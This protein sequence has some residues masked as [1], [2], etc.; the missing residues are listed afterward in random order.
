MRSEEKRKT[1]K[2]RAGIEKFSVEER[3][4]EAEKLDKKLLPVEEED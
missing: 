3:E 2:L 4:K 1:G